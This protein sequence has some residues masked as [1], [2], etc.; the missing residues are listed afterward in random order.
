MRLVRELFKF[1]TNVGLRKH[2]KSDKLH[3]LLELGAQ[4]DLKTGLLQTNSL[5]TVGEIQRKRRKMK[6]LVSTLWAA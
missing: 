3:E 4:V 6:Q 1:Y 2:G 5:P